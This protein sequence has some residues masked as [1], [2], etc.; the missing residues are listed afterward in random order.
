M[1]LI[2]EIQMNAFMRGKVREIVTAPRQN[3]RLILNFTS[4][5]YNTSTDNQTVFI[6]IYLPE[7]C[8]F[9]QFKDSPHR[10]CGGR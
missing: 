1:I 3:I 2:I 9:E 5:G 8:T 4:F 6:I 10:G 7:N